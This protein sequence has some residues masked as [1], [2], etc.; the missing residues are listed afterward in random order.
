MLQ[1]SIRTS[2]LTFPRP[3][4]ATELCK[5]VFLD[6]AHAKCT[7]FHVPTS[8]LPSSFSGPKVRIM[9]VKPF[10]CA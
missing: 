6:S 3:T 1:V 8:T 4:R 2:Q 7:D 5:R 9:Y 10:I